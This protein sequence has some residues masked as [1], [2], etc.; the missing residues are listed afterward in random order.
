MLIPNGY[1][2]IGNAV[3]EIQM[4]SMFSSSTESKHAEVE[5][6]SESQII[7]R[8]I[9]KLLVD[10]LMEAFCICVRTG[11][12][13]TV[14]LEY[15][16]TPEAVNVLHG[17]T[18]DGLIWELEGCE[19]YPVLPILPEPTLSK[20]FPHSGFMENNM[21][22]VWPEGWKFSTKQSQVYDASSAAVVLPVQT[23]NAGGRPLKFDW[24][25]FWIEVVRFV[26]D[27]GL[28]DDARVECQKHMLS[29]TA[30]RWDPPP[31][32]STIRQKL[33]KVFSTPINIK[34]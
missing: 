12:L 7:V 2:T 11:Y 32:E 3:D 5:N 29:W 8:E 21:P 18:K 28:A 14:P 30:K 10:G 9:G 1:L 26:A 24:D 19:H 20:M 27:S 25:D 17:K 4:D 34:K 33:V 6:D 15:W 22:V 16:R 13:G 23:K 31:G